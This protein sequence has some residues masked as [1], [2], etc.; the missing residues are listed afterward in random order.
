MKQVPNWGPTNIR[1]HITKLESRTT[2]RPGIFVDLVEMSRCRLLR[3][4]ILQWHSSAMRESTMNLKK[5]GR[6]RTVMRVKYTDGFSLVYWGKLRMCT[7]WR[8]NSLVETRDGPAGLL[9]W[10]RFVFTHDQAVRYYLSTVKIGTSA[11]ANQYWILVKW[12]SLSCSSCT[13][14]IYRRP[15]KC[16]KL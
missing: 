4:W 8:I 5:G 1:R 2:R 12:H 7:D 13:S 15:E 9:I 6:E 16:K 11:L 3:H 10:K 14:P